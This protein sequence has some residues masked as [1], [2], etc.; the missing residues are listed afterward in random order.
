MKLLLKIL[1]W[2]VTVALSVFT[3]ICLFL[4]SRAAFL[5]GLASTLLTAL[6]LLVLLAG[7]LKNAAIVTVIAFLISPY[8]LP[9]VAARLIG[10]VASVN[11]AIKD[12]LHE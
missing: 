2:P 4:F 8:G 9:M 5:L 7:S 3:S 11:A 12:F 10:G 6:A 1:V